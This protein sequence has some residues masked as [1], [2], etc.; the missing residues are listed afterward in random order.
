M[1][2]P[3]AYWSDLTTK[4][5]PRPHITFNTHIVGAEWDVALQLHH[6]RVQTLRDGDAMKERVVRPRFPDIEGLGV[7]GGER[8][9]SAKWEHE[10]QVKGKRVAVIGSESSAIQCV[11]KLAQ[12]PSIEVVQFIR[13]P[14]WYIP[15]V[16]I[17]YS[18]FVDW[19]LTHIPRAMR[20][21]RNRIFLQAHL[22]YFGRRP[23]IEVP[24][25][26][27]FAIPYLVGQMKQGLLEHMQQTCRQEYQQVMTPDFHTRTTAPGCK[28]LL[29]DAGY[30]PGVRDDAGEEIPIDVIIFAT[31]FTAGKYPFHV[32][33][34]DGEAIQGYYKEYGGPTAYLDTTAPGLPS[35]RCALHSSHSQMIAPVFSGAASSFVVTP[36]ACDAYNAKIQRRLEGSV[37][38][39][40]VPWYRAGGTRQVTSVFPGP[41]TLFWCRMRKPVW[42][43]G[44]R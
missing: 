18:S 41:V 22:N 20:M 15:K 14:S 30:L 38:M 23:S 19:I 5:D 3:D 1:T 13:A 10:V 25:F 33:G 26:G 35:L 42:G 24:C 6:F 2:Q 44:G 29:L 16:E 11:P 28:R 4:D 27:L 21:Y 40:C 31:G 17:A 39:Q 7:L 36:A 37:L 12:D 8:F 9:R 43:S 32:S 34:I